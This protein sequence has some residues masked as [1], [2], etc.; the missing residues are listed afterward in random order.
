MG[1]IVVMILK[2]KAFLVLVNYFD[3][4]AESLHSHR[5]N[6][7]TRGNHDSHF[8]ISEEG[9]SGFKRKL[10]GEEVAGYG[11]LWKRLKEINV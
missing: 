2:L 7:D 9:M 11:Q 6:A 4:T 1:T 3:S 5:T 10:T 8:S